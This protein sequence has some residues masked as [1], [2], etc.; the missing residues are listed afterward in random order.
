MD[1]DRVD[2]IA[3]VLYKACQASGIEKDSVEWLNVEEKVYDIYTEMA[4][5]LTTIR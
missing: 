2:E 3:E 4:E 1:D 5:L